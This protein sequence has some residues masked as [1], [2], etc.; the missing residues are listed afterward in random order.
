M[1]ANRKRRAV[2]PATLASTAFGGQLLSAALDRAMLKPFAQEIWTAEGPNI[3]IAGF[4]YPTRMAVIRLSEASL[5]IWSPIELTDDPRTAVDSLGQVRHIVA[6]NSLHH[7]FLRGWRRA[8]P[9]GRLCPD[10]FAQ[11]T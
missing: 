2:T 5:F 9:G 7:L 8:Y 4:H 10:G 3:V 11:E 1:F 6:P